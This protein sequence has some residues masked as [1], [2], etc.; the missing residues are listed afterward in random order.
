[1]VSLLSISFQI[2]AEHQLGEA[3]PIQFTVTNETD[4]DVQFLK[5]GTPLEGVISN[6]FAIYCD[7]TKVAY[8]G[9]LVKYGNPAPDDYVTLR[10]SESISN[11]VNLADYY[12]IHSSGDYQLEIRSDIQDCYTVS[13]GEDTSPRPLSQHESYKLSKQKVSFKVVGEGTPRETVA[14]K[15][16]AKEAQIA[17][18]MA[19]A[20][21]LAMFKA[22]GPQPPL[23]PNIVGGTSAQQEEMKQV[24]QAANVYTWG[25]IQALNAVQS[26]Q[27]TNY[28]TWFGSYDASRFST[29]KTNYQQI[30]NVLGSQQ[31]TYDLT[32]SGCPSSSTYAYTYKGS[33]TVYMCNGY[34]NAPFCGQDSKVGTTIHEL[35]H[36][37]AY[38][39][40]NVYG[41]TSCK[42]L[43]NTNPAK[44]IENA[45]SYEYFAET[46]L[47]MNYQFDSAA[48]LPNGKT[49]VT[50]GNIYIRYS[51]SNASTIDSGYP[52]PLQVN[53]GNLPT[54][55]AEGFDSM[56]AL[57]NGKIYVTKGNQYIRY[58]DSSASTIDSGYPLAIQGNWGSLPATFNAGFDSMT[59]LPNGKIYVTK[60]AQ[61]VRYSDSNA[62]TV[63]PG[64]PLQIAGHWGN[65]PASF[66]SGFDSMCVLGNNKTYVT[67][68]AEY[69]RYSDNNASTIDSGYPLQIADNWGYPPDN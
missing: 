45:D 61:Y 68:D 59:V 17:P 40:D 25:C 24:H 41:R 23:S 38:T 18:Q 69:I 9:I 5:W 42:N 31:I 49:Y 52:L 51:D 64:Y 34:F 47:P 65:T 2:A 14:G 7:G 28:V 50:L 29:V 4:K 19:K 58:S 55:F 44:A 37:V 43:A 60:G 8:D 27:N 48:R 39:D 3:I 36:A 57:A 63:D 11:E 15:Q 35:S 33:R 67:S 22:S 21:P 6:L 26:A 10:A 1:M 12:D 16:R 66:N 13:Q 62:S 30:L 20:Q 32:K 46:T 53:W 56:S 54:A